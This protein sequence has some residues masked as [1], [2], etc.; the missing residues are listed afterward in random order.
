MDIT[1]KPLQ[2]N[3]LPLLFLWLEKPHVKAWWDPDVQWTME[4]IQEKFGTYVDGYNLEDGVKKPL[5]AFI[6]EID[7][8]PVGYVHLY[9][10]RDYSRE[11][12][13]P[14]DELPDSCTGLDTSS[15]TGQLWAEAMGQ[16]YCKSFC[17]STSLLNMG[18]VLSIQ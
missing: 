9:N 10:L 17:S 1:F 12:G 18:P 2:T 6:V 7:N 14:E 11:D 16:R 5:Q 4:L 15:A 3:H 13:I 8:E